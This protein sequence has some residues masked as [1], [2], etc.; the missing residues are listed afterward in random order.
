MFSFDD[1]LKTDVALAKLL[2]KYGLKA[3]FFVT[4]GKVDRGFVWLSREDVYWLSDVHEIGSHTLSHPN[5][6]KLPEG[7]LIR[8]LRDSKLLLEQVID[9]RISG[10]AYP[11]GIFNEHV[12]KYVMRAGYK[13]ARSTNAYWIGV[14]GFI[15]DPYS[16]RV[17]LPLYPLKLIGSIQDIVNKLRPIFFRA[18]LSMHSSDIKSFLTSMIRRGYLDTFA[19]VKNIISV[20]IEQS[21]RSKTH[22][23][24]S[25]WGHSWEIMLD[26]DAR[27]KFED[28]LA[29]ISSLSRSVE[30]LTIREVIERASKVGFE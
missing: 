7:K 11:Y 20:L 14:N 22:Y 26:K 4:A 2:E 15:G 8:E 6:V 10:L 9:K 17:T 18:Y 29:F 13:Y 3:T 27:L 5:L 12:K 30:V 25:L 19:F 16:L 23:V 21:R 28:L 24:I 1:G